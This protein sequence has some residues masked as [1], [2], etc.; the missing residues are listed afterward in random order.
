MDIKAFPASIL[1]RIAVD[2]NH[3]SVSYLTA[4]VR[5]TH[6]QPD[7]SSSSIRHKDKLSTIL[8]FTIAQISPFTDATYKKNNGK[9]EAED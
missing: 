9:H 7:C 2:I 5:I 3:I 6:Q 1:K 8:H 4:G